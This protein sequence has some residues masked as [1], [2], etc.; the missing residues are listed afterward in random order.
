[1]VS[2]RNRWHVE[3]VDKTLTLAARG[4]LPVWRT[5]PNV[6]L[7]WD[8]GLPSAMA[9]LEEAKL[10]FAIRL[11]TVDN[12]HPLV[13]RITPLMCTRGRGAGSR[14]RP[15]TKVQRLGALLPSVPRPTLRA[16]HF[17]AGCRT[18][19][20]G[21]LDKKTASAKFKKWWAALPAEDVT[22]FLVGSERYTDVQRHIG[23]G[24]AIIKK[25]R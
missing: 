20:T 3:I 8:S 22:I 5:T 23:Y 18:D 25:G 11:Q 13:R 6:T 21:G 24:Y 17:T 2:A 15:K 7:F 12:Q 19:L 16:P 10:R 14:Q 4:V 1:M 9:A